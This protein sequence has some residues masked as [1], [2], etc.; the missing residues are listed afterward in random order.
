VTALK[1][2]QQSPLL[3][4]S[5]LRIGGGVRPQR[6]LLIYRQTSPVYL[7]SS[8]LRRRSILTAGVP[9]PNDGHRCLLYTSSVHLYY[10]GYAWVC[11]T[12]LSGSQNSVTYQPTARIMV[13]VY[14][15]QDYN[16]YYM[17]WFQHYER[18]HFIVVRDYFSI[19]FIHP[20]SI[21][22]VGMNWRRIILI[23][24]RFYFQPSLLV[25]NIPVHLYSPR[26]R[27]RF[28]RSILTA[29]MRPSPFY[30]FGFNIMRDLDS[31][32]WEITNQCYDRL[33]CQH[34]EGFSI[35]ITHTSRLYLP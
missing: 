6:R 24:R 13:S 12:L 32:L 20:P 18:L 17:V 9:P 8:R 33:L 35:W 34:Y 27:R 16:F 19:W 25:I 22:T 3:Y 23:S 30:T 1:P 21:F 31:L 2:T 26:L 10:G 15:A 5:L 29:V 4:S 28:R 14:R 7:Y 11:F